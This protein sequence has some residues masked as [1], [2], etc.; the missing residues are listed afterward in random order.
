MQ[1]LFSPAPNLHLF[2][3]RVRHQ[4]VMMRERERYPDIFRR[5]KEKQLSL[6]ATLNQTSEVVYEY[7][8]PWLEHEQQRSFSIHNKTN[9]TWDGR[10]KVVRDECNALKCT[11]GCQPRVSVNTYR[12]WRLLALC[13]F[14]WTGSNNIEKLVAINTQHK[15][16]QFFLTKPKKIGEP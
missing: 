4:S 10:G 5:W 15:T 9:A 1:T 7:E 16:P 12:A 6:R 2:N 14:T 8:R 13:P 11:K 3:M